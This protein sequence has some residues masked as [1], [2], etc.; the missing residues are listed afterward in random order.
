M[1]GKFPEHGNPSPN[2]GARF[3]PF[4]TGNYLF[5]TQS[6]LTEG[7]QS[8]AFRELNRLVVKTEGLGASTAT[9]RLVDGWYKAGD[10][11]D[12]LYVPGDALT[13]WR[14]S[15]EKSDFYRD[16]IARSCR[17]CHTAL[18]QQFNWDDRP[19][20]FASDPNSRDA[21]VLA[22][23]CGGQKDLAVNASMPNALA[24]LDRLLDANVSNAAE[25]K[26]RMLKYL[27]CTAPVPDPVYPRR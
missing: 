12:K 25:I 15:T 24:S 11:L 21:T 8:A 13:G 19:A 16:V 27:G 23:V 2:L 3:L 20:R 4:D 10:A 9:T 22:H 7:A 17:T 5:S 14:E 6:V 26:S 1:G 18:G